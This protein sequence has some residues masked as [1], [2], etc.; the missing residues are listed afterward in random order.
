[1]KRGDWAGDGKLQR[2]IGHRRVANQLEQGNVGDRKRQARALWDWETSR[3]RVVNHGPTMGS[4]TTG[5][6][7]NALNSGMAVRCLQES[8]LTLSPPG[9]WLDYT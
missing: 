7:Q 5:I 3:N 9:Q 6:R 2:G 1:M 8:G 4:L